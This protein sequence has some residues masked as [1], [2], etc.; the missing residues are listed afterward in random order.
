ML[1]A[2]GVPV[3]LLSDTPLELSEE[4]YPA[5]LPD[6]VPTSLC[7]VPSIHADCLDFCTMIARN[8]AGKLDFVVYRQHSAKDPATTTAYDDPVQVSPLIDQVHCTQRY[9][10]NQSDLFDPFVTMIG[11]GFTDPRWKGLRMVYQDRYPHRFK[12][13]YRYQVVY[14]DADGEIVGYRESGWLRAF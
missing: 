10:V 2:D 11:G 13:W 3:L 9:D 6:C 7:L 14:F 12:D 4:C 8:L 1:G 5:T